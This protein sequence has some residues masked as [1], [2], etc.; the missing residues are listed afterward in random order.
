MKYCDIHG[1]VDS[2]DPGCPICQTTLTD[3]PRGKWVT[4]MAQRAD[5]EKLNTTPPDNARA[6]N[7]RQGAFLAAYEKGGRVD[8]A[9]EAAGIDRTSHYYWLRTDTDYKAAFEESEVIVG[10]NLMDEAVRR[11][12]EGWEEPV[13]VA[14]QAVMVRK[15][16]DR[17]LERLL[18]AHH[19]EKFRANLAHR[20][21]DKRGEDRP[22]FD[23]AELDKLIRAADERDKEHS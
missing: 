11:A 8:K 3:E 16:S 10:Q 18:E 15:F 12:M 4:I 5:A 7:R 2:S 20:L 23:V 17:L 13:T 6:L 14:G 19:P 1:P 21:V 9:A 22:M